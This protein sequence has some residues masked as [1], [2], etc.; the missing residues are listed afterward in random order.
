LGLSRYRLRSCAFDPG[1][2]GSDA[3]D[4]RRRSPR[5]SPREPSAGRPLKPVP[6]NCAASRGAVARSWVHLPRQSRPSLETRPSRWNRTALEPHGAGTARRWNRPRPEFAALEPPR[7]L[8][9]HERPPRWNHRAKS[10]L[11]PTSPQAETVSAPEPSCAP[12]TAASR[13]PINE[14]AYPDA[15]ATPPPT[16]TPPLRPAPPPPPPGRDRVV[17]IGWARSSGGTRRWGGA[18]HC[19]VVRSVPCGSVPIARCAKRP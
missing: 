8:S 15:R 19:C 4:L 7:N 11:T 1:N 5:P 14:L 2:R 9:P 16:P 18:R 10:T 17:V 6:G 3:Q 13:T 12:A